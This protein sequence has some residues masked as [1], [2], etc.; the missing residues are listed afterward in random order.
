MGE[1]LALGLGAGRTCRQGASRARVC[2]L[3]RGRGQGQQGVEEAVKAAP[4]PA[5]APAPVSQSRRPGQ[6]CYD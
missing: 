4:P 6:G 5:P 3:E 1:G 2:C